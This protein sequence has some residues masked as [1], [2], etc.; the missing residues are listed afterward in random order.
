MGLLNFLG[1]AA[2][3]LCLYDSYYA[4]KKMPLRYIAHNIK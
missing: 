3:V 2:L 1:W 4:F